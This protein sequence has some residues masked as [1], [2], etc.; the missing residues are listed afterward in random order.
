MTLYDQCVDL[1]VKL[2]AAQTADASVAVVAKA[3]QLVQVLNEAS[4]YL[5]GIEAFKS[6]MNIQ[7]R[8]PL[9][10]A[11]VM[12]AVRAFRGG[13]SS[14][15]ANAFQHQPAAKL[16][17][18]TKEQQAR[19]TRWATSRWRE[20]FDPYQPLIERADPDQMVGNSIHRVT[21]QA[22]AATL[23]MVKGLD[24]ITKADELK[25]RLG[26]DDGTAAWLDTIDSIAAQLQQALQAIDAERAALSPEVQQI[27]QMAS[28]EEGFALSDLTTSLLD[29]LRLAGID[30]DLV[31]RRR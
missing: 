10:A 12:E 23:T 4:T 18:V 17:R 30:T 2:D 14:H 22:R 29:G 1:Q 19:A 3:R 25:A 11:A 8:P 24:P 7:E 27:L 20:L 21:A 31:V 16:D 15:G 6:R 26:G 28:S 13:L 9:D 5:A